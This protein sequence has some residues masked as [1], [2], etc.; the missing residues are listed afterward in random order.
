MYKHI[1]ISRVAANMLNKQSRTADSGWSCSQGLVGG[2]T[3][4][5]RKTQYLLRI[6]THSL[7]RTVVIAVMNLRV[8][9]PRS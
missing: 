1:F 7:G 8:L 3:T 9:S 2:L 4:L 6:T 5:P